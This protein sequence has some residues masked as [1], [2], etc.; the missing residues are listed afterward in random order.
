M[1]THPGGDA[2]PCIEAAKAFIAE[3]ASRIATA[4]EGT[5]EPPSLR[6]VAELSQPFLEAA[7]RAGCSLEITLE[8][9][10]QSAAKK[11]LDAVMEALSAHMEEMDEEE[12][13]LL[14]IVFTRYAFHVARVA[15]AALD[16]GRSA[17]PEALQALEPLVF[18][19]LARLLAVT[20]YVQSLPT[21]E[22][23]R[24][25]QPLVEMINRFIE[26]ELGS[27]QAA[28]ALIQG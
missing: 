9:A 8:Q 27:L 12:Y 5:S 19:S 24:R 16:A 4:L 1:P 3:L 20:H 2:A 7:S 22:L 15:A 10:Y 28:L 26:E 6:D 23:R 25:T 14:S 17:G 18:A 13:N 21:R 11:A